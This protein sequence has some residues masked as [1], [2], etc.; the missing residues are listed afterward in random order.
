MRLSLLVALTALA[1][2]CS[3]STIAPP[4]G[5]PPACTF[6]NPLGPGADPWVIR[7]DGA[8]YFAQSHDD[9]IWVHRTERLTDIDASYG[10]EVWTAPD[11]GWN[12]TN[13]WA[14]ELHYIDGHWYIYYAAGRA[15]PPFIWQRAG[16][17]AATTD[18]PQGPYVDRG[19]LVTGDDTAGGRDTVWAIDL[20]VE[21]LGGQLYAVWSGWDRNATTDRTPQNLYIARMTDPVT[22]GSARVRIS[23]P[24][25]SWERG[26]ELDLEEGPEFLLHGDRTFIVYSTRESW[27]RDY[28]LGELRLAS[29]DADPMRPESWVKRGPVF[30]GTTGVYGVGHAS[31]TTSPDG[32]EDWIVY[33]TK[34]D[35]TPGWERLV[36]T[37]RFGWADDGEPEFGTPLPDGE[38]TPDPSG[39]CP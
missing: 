12:R 10:T 16:V 15:G 28:R 14:P 33:H 4:G 26:T 35:S 23:A 19:M 11:T 31:F 25:E 21:R 36:R 22:I 37:Q 2:G 39:Q 29:A 27:L 38:R 32:T 18:D 34:V 6:T 9:A 30:T 5:P 1:G 17:L 7:H 20:T 8:Y 13:I 24:T 3:S